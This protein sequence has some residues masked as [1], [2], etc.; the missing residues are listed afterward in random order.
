[1]PTVLL[2]D[3]QIYYSQVWRLQRPSKSP[4]TK[5][6]T[7]KASEIVSEIEEEVLKSQLII[8][9]VNSTRES[10]QQNQVYFFPPFEGG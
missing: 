9:A 10:L 4:R 3:D 8:K 6:E 1:M 5:I 2:S 7:E